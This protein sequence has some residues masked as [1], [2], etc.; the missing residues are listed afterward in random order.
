M[1]DSI[2]YIV[3]KRRMNFDYL[4][5]VHMGE[6]YWMNMMQLTQHD[7]RQYMPANV[8]V[9][10]SRNWF[11][12]AMSVGNLLHLERGAD[13]LNALHQLM[14]EYEY[15]LS[16]PSTIKEKKM[17]LSN[18]HS[19]A[20]SSLDDEIDKYSNSNIHSNSHSHG[21]RNSNGN[22]INTTTNNDDDNDSDKNSG[23]SGGRGRS[24]HDQENNN[25]NR[26]YDSARSVGGVQRGTSQ[27]GKSQTKR[28]AHRTKTT[29]TPKVY[30]VNRK[31]VA[32][33][34]LVAPSLPIFC[35]EG[36]LDYCEVVYSLC[37]ALSMLYEKFT[38]ES[39]LPPPPII[40][41]IVV[42]VDEVVKR[43]VIKTMSDDVASVVE[44]LLKSNLQM[45]L[46]PVCL[47]TEAHTADHEF[48]D[49]Y[50]NVSIGAD[51]G[52]AKNANTGDSATA[53]GS[54]G[55]GNKNENGDAVLI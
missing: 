8:L 32:F 34:Y 28:R 30:K 22:G 21:N 39:C 31:E 27:A 2:T 37:D 12:L 53:A 33:K 11:V 41:E 9:K 51:H 55:N 10:R 35:E 5:R 38:D 46:S 1:S 29:L 23:S 42:K 50:I 7:I 40:H 4:K 47:S 52:D 6:L 26:N 45:L 24:I 18:A 20:T 14:K 15:S 54:N 48:H 13:A 36:A 3:K 44:P 16:H 25:V 17:W 49:Q 19:F 43:L